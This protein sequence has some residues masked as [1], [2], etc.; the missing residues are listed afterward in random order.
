MLATAGIL[1]I[2]LLLLGLPIFILLGGATIIPMILDGL[3]PLQYP[4]MATVQS[5]DSFTYMA[6]PFFIL[7][8][9]LMGR[10]G[11]SK[12]LVNFVSTLVGF[13]PGG[14]AVVTVVSCTLF[15]AI[16]GS[17]P[18]T[19][20]AIGGIM[21][22]F[23]VKAGYG[24]GFSAAL[25]A[26][27]GC[28]GL[29]IP[30]SIGMITYGVTAGAS[31]ADLFSAGIFPGILSMILLCIWSIYISKKRNYGEIVKFDASK[32]FPAFK[33]A[34][35]SLLMPIIILG[36]IYSGVFTPT[37][38]SAVACLYALIIG[39]LVTKKLNVKSL[40]DGLKDSA[41]TCATILIIIGTAGLFGRLLTMER[42]PQVLTSFVVENDVTTVQFLLFLNIVMLF[43]G[44]FMELN[45]TILILT[46]V[47]L[48][49][50]KS[51]GIDPV[52]MGAIMV[53]N[54]TYGLI[55]PPLG[56]NLYVASGITNIKVEETIK[57]IW[58]FIITGIMVILATTF[59][60]ELTLMFV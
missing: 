60:P 20:A 8:G 57:E 45:A 40:L 6:I 41:V 9:D 3:Y 2:V 37:E 29:M 17:A 35:W 46:P 59:L 30:P 58:P 1:F 24:A 27:S 36:G 11:I 18:A 21:I 52:H 5:I 47:V 54:M 38:S 4:A 44:T 53:V 19:V 39:F 43:L 49:I 25:S 15:G 34:I 14:L 33:E 26:T 10:G 23:M 22:P 42:L 16:S 12:G 31:I 56:I 13:V 55:T 48:P 28:I 51:L 32:I 50:A 7:S